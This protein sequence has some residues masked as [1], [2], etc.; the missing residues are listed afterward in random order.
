MLAVFVDDSRQKLS[1]EEALVAVCDKFD[2]NAVMVDDPAAA[3]K[4]GL[5]ADQLPAYVYFED[6][7]PAVFENQDDDD[8]QSG[9]IK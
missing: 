3:V 6:G 1:N 2:I 5:E 9:Y 4:Y 8:D 7:V